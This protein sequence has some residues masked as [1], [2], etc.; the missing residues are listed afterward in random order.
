L[1]LRGE[2]SNQKAGGIVDEF[3]IPLQKIGARHLVNVIGRNAEIFDVIADLRPDPL[4]TPECNSQFSSF[5][6]A[7]ERRICGVLV[8]FAK[9]GMRPDI[10]A[11]AACDVVDAENF[12]TVI[13][14]SSRKELSSTVRD[15][16]RYYDCVARISRSY[17]V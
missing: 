17:R 8:I 15:G 4:R 9:L 12:S 14:E 3:D 6:Q 7:P 11:A 16:I 2:S 10:G 5:G 13:L 1:F